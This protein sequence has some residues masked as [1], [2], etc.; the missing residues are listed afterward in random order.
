MP[1]KNRF[2]LLLSFFIFLTFSF[3]PLITISAPPSE[4]VLPDGDTVVPGGDVSLLS[5]SEPDAIAIRIIPN[6]E[7]YNIQQWY[8]MQG[9]T[10]S[11]QSLLV[12]GYKAIRDGRTVYISAANIDPDQGKIYFNIYLI[13]YNQ[14]ADD[15]TIDIFGK[16]LSNWRLN[17]NLKDKVGNCTISTKVCNSSSDCPSGYICGGYASVDSSH[18]ED[19]NDINNL[20]QISQKN[21]CIIAE[22]DYNQPLV[23]TPACLLDSECPNNLFCDSPKAKLI[24]DMDRLEKLNTIK[25]K[26]EAYKNAN[27][28]YPILSSGTYVPHLAISSWPSWQKVFLSQINS[29]GLTDNINRISSC[30]DEEN[31]FDLTTC[32]ENNKSAFL[33]VK[34]PVNFTNFVL[35]EYSSVFSYVSDPQGQVASLYSPMESADYWGTDFDLPSGENTNDFEPPYIPIDDEL[36]QY[37]NPYFEE[38]LLSGHSGQ[39]FSGYIK[40]K[41]P[42]GQSLNWYISSCIPGK[43]LYPDGTIINNCSDFSWSS[44]TPNKFPA[45]ENSNSD[46]MIYLKATKAGESESINSSNITTRNKRYIVG[47]SIKNSSGYETIKNFPIYISNQNPNV[48]ASSDYSKDLSLYQDFSF[49]ISISDIS[50]IQTISLCHLDSSNNCINTWDLD[51]NTSKSQTINFTN[52]ALFNDK[53]IMNL[54]ALGEDNNSYSLNIENKYSLNTPKVF[55][56]SHIGTHKFKITAKDPYGAQTYKFFKITFTANPPVVMFNNCSNNA[57]LNSSYSCQVSSNKPGESLSAES[58]EKPSFLSF[59]TNTKTF[60]GTASVLGNHKIR[61][62]ITNDFGL[63]AEGSLNLSVFTKPSV[64]TISAYDIGSNLFTCSGRIVSAGGNQTGGHGCV[65]STNSANLDV[66]NTAACNASNGCSYV[67]IMQD[68]YS[69]IHVNAGLNRNTSYYYR[70]YGTNLAGTAYGATKSFKTRADYPKLTVDNESLSGGSINFRGSLVD[71]GGGDIISGTSRILKMGFVWSTNLSALESIAGTCTLNPNNC[72]LADSP[73]VVGNFA[74]SVSAS[75]FTPGKT[76]YFK[77]FALNKDYVGERIGFSNYDTLTLPTPPSVTTVSPNTITTSSVKSGG[78]ISNPSSITISECGLI[79]WSSDSAHTTGETKVKASSCS[80]NFEL[81]IP[82]LSPG[83]AYNLKAYI[84]SDFGTVYG[85]TFPFTTKI[86]KNITYSGNGSTSGTP[87]ATQTANV[88]DSVIISSQNTLAKT[89]NTF[90]GW[91]TN[92]EG[93]GDSYNVNESISMPPLGLNLYAKWKPDAYTVTFNKD[94]GTG[95]SSSV[96]A[97]YGSNMPTATAPTRDGYNFGGYYSAVNGG[98]TQYYTNTMASARTWNLAANTTLYAKWTST[99]YTVTFD[100]QGGTGGSNSVTVAY[101]SAMPSATAPTKTGYTFDGYYGPGFPVQVPYYSS[102]MSSVRNWDKTSNATLY[103]KWT[104]STVCSIAY[105]SNGSTGGSLP[106]TLPTVY[107]CGENVVLATN[108]GNLSKTGHTFS[109][110]N[111][112]PNGTGTHYNAGA[113]L[114]NISSAITLYAE[115]TANTYYLNFDSQGGNSIGSKTV[116]YGSMVGL[117]ATPIRSGYTFGGWYTNTNGG[118][119]AYTGTTIYNFP[120][121]TTLYAKWSPTYILTLNFT[122]LYPSNNIRISVNNNQYICYSYEDTCSYNITGGTEVTLYTIAPYPYKFNFY[123]N[124]CIGKTNPTCSFIINN[125]MEVTSHIGCAA[126]NVQCWQ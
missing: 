51:P 55:N 12:D 52:S 35:P 116:T 7:N 98:G 94:N 14:E 57:S 123:E 82:N 77:S 63:S 13:S 26:L 59:N 112:S 97:Y 36:P 88:G 81:S 31:N 46:E 18:L 49:P 41:D 53:L 15:N 60:S 54:S 11:P 87:P 102:S 50:G 74:K 9:F 104:S 100:K 96:T 32:W 56:S 73:Y 6:P 3:F 91:S 69:F 90:V 83:V 58:L 27:G 22:A 1:K 2:N 5:D 126:E 92:A 21:R 103:A 4:D 47:V 122:P 78:N 34:N 23:N 86:S 106:T 43:E 76:Y 42:R 80:S 113:T 89:G 30:Y 93:T 48:Q 25:V 62:K 33:N 79:Y 75:K 67:A 70:A 16:I 119:T 72:I 61:V 28:H 64:E 115:W 24:R 19:N 121:N 118:G 45:K 68:N 40:A 114:N 17:T 117:L 107:D 84:A 44:W 65:V 108:S 39:E 99:S 125:N 110:W 20:G 71:D 111:S 29:S 124:V 101:G 95:G 10:G 66:T 120:G 8:R 85:A 37:N 38:V 109:G 105:N